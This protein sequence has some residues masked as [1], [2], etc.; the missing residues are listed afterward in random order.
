M[1]LIIWVVYCSIKL[2]AGIFVP[3]LAAGAALGRIV[4]VS[5]QHLAHRFP[6]CSFLPPEDHISPGVYALIGA[7]ATLA[8]VTRT[9]VSL[10]VIVVELTG[11]LDYVVPVAIAILA[12][13]VSS[14]AI[15]AEGI[16]DLVIGLNDFPYLDCKKDHHFGSRSI[17]DVVSR[18]PVAGRR[19][20][21]SANTILQ[22][23]TD[24]PYILVDQKHTVASLQAKLADMIKS[25]HR[26]GCF[27]CLKSQDGSTGLGLVG[28]LAVNELHHALGKTVVG[29]DEAR[30]MA[31]LEDISQPNSKMTQMRHVTYCLIWSTSPGR[32]RSTAC[33]I[34]WTRIR[35]TYPSL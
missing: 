11:T 6:Y 17:Y 4:G 33:S 31:D 10:A 2:P 32:I 13:K 1:I 23:D 25:G 19:I 26:D 18:S 12:A 21:L 16:Y 3:S 24:L 34:V 14:D 9:T 7:A 28:V 8:G 30:H 35:M 29:R 20:S 22:V 15:L 5:L 27:P